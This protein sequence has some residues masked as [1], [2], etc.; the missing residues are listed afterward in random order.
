LN[1]D[2][3]YPNTAGNLLVQFTS[4][5][6]TD[7]TF[8]VEVDFKFF[9]RFPFFSLTSRTLNPTS[10]TCTL[11]LPVQSNSKSVANTTHSIIVSDESEEEKQPPKKKKK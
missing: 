4:L 2:A 1:T 8:I 10:S 3:A 11:A 7:V 5:A 6:A 9:R